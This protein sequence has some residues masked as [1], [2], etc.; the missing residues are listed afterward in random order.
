MDTVNCVFLSVVLVFLLDNMFLAAQSTLAAS[1][2]S[3]ASIR[4]DKVRQS[5]NIEIESVLS[6]GSHTSENAA[7]VGSADIPRTDD[8]ANQGKTHVYR[9]A[10]VANQSKTHVYRAA[11]LTD[12]GKSDARQTVNISRQVRAHHATDVFLIDSQISNNASN[13]LPMVEEQDQGDGANSSDADGEAE[14]TSWAWL[15]GN[16][17][18]QTYDVFDMLVAIATTTAILLAVVSVSAFLSHCIKHRRHYSPG[19]GDTCIYGYGAPDLKLGRRQRHTTCLQAGCCDAY[20]SSAISSAGSMHSLN[21]LSIATVEMATQYDCGDVLMA[22]FVSDEL[23]GE[24]NDRSSV[25][26]AASDGFTY[27]SNFSEPPVTRHATTEF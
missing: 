8:V 20:S 26:T 24:L 2:K 13:V 4:R 6:F 25:C 15:P 12:E 7:D 5:S 3:V 23:I 9:A 14:A 1:S 27:C 10:D 17:A 22:S 18:R 11:V 19:S 21:S 16:L